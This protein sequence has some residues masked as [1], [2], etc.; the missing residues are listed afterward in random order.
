MDPAFQRFTDSVRDHLRSIYGATPWVV[1]SEVLQGA[2]WMASDLGTAWDADVFALGVVTGVGPIDESVP[3][4]VIGPTGA[5]SMLESI[6]AA[7][8]ALHDPPAEVLSAID[9]WDPDGVA[10]SIVDFTMSGGTVGGRRSYGARLQPWIDLEDKLVA[11]EIWADAG[12][13]TAPDAV[14][15][16]S[17]LDAC[18]RA[19]HEL[20]SDLGTVWA[21]DNRD[22]WHGG[23]DGTRWVHDGDAVEDA[24]EAMRHRHDVVRIMPF[25][26]G[27]PCSVHGMVLDDATIAFR[28][29]EL[30]I[31]R[32]PDE[33][34]I[35][36]GKA[37]SFW[38]PPE[39]DRAEM[40]AAAKSVGE[41]LRS[42]ADFRGVFTL[43]GV[44]G[45]G[46]FV[47]TEVN[48]RFGGALPGLTATP[49]GGTI[50]LL[51]INHAVVENDYPG[52]DAGALEEWVLA[53]LDARRRGIGML[54]TAAAPEH[55]RQMRVGRGDR[56]EL[57]EV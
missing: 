8:A 57:V 42:R 3:H 47:P 2:V 31:Y 34:R 40:R 41:A 5:T 37:A 53:D 23:V 33:H 52:L 19:H 1:C 24:I 50:N 29:M 15:S 10:R 45:A 22:G 13:S 38:D 56:G 16:L 27:V 32:Q 49:D 54:E 21:G 6:R 25:V 44:L 12:I 55:E 14:V 28:P 18:R 20:A 9:A 30:C 26:E 43:D 11:R 46:G 35:V 36:Y 39:S 4:A 48:P 51:H 17:D 7:D